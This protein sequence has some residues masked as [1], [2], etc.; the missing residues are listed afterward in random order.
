M[1]EERRFLEGRNLV[2]DCPYC[3][4]GSVPVVSGYTGN[5]YIL[6]S[7]GRM[8]IVCGQCRAVFSMD[9]SGS[10]RLSAAESHDIATD[11]RAEHWKRQF[12]DEC[13]RLGFWG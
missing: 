9:A 1:V 2:A 3:Q 12:D 8:I 11:P 5:E 13:V 7:T 10:Y 6:K 4:A